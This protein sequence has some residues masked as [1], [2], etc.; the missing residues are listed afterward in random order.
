MVIDLTRARHAD[1]VSI[2]I[3]S[4]ANNAAKAALKGVSTSA[5]L[6]HVCLAADC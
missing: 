3:G 4:K 6:S 5:I 1:E 2:L